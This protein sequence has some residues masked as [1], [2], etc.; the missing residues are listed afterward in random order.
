MPATLVAVAYFCW[1]GVQPVAPEVSMKY[2]PL[3]LNMA[4]ASR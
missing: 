3:R 4:G 1:L 2:T